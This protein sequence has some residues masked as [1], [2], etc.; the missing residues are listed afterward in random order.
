MRIYKVISAS[1]DA[2]EAPFVTMDSGRIRFIS[3]AAELDSNGKIKNT[4]IQFKR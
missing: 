1:E 2:P 3:A 4:I